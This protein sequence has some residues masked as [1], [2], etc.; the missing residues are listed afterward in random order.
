MKS[1]FK[2]VPLV[3]AVLIAL[4]SCK[5]QKAALDANQ[6]PAVVE[7][8]TVPD[9]Q[10]EPEVMPEPKDT[11][12]APSATLDARLS[13]Y[14]G[15]I[16]SA[17]S[18]S[19]ANNNIREALGLFST[20]DAPVLIIFYAAN[21]TED[22]DE[23]TTISKYLNYLKDVKLNPHKVKEVVT[24]PQGKIKELVLVKK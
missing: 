16:A 21:G 3:F 13:N 6:E 7:E 4:S 9:P 8:E 24:D 2:V 18:V 1:I 17:T 14:F 11:R 20:G 22:Y 5:S 12:D 10:P 23:P 15:A 19:A